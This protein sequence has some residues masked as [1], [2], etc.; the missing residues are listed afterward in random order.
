MKYYNGY[1]ETVEINSHQMSIHDV[2]HLILELSGEDNIQPA[3]KKILLEN[4]TTARA[5]YW[6]AQFEMTEEQK[7][8]LN[9]LG[10]RLI[11]QMEEMH[12]LQKRLLQQEQDRKKN[13]KQYAKLIKLQVI[14]KDCCSE[15]ASDEEVD[16]Y[17]E[18]FT[19]Q[20]AYYNSSYIYT[21]EDEYH[22]E[23]W[24]YPSQKAE[25]GILTIVHDL[26][27]N[28]KLAWKDLTYIGD[29][30]MKVKYYY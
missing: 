28:A 1:P 27:Q 12:V 15:D 22:C 30:G 3:Y 19:F 17:S 7:T 13:G 2:E 6:D 11:T 21:E 20:K 16:L 9:E 4:Y 14:I 29:F 18:L 24:K 25:D 23:R 5:A 8:K 10:D 26:K